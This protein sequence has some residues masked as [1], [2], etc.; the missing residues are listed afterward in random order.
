MKF[1][2]DKIL[3]ESDAYDYDLTSRILREYPAAQ[4]K[5]GEEALLELRDMELAGDP[6]RLGKRTLRLMIGKGA[7]VKDCP[8]TNN[9]VCCGLKIL[10]FGQGCPMDCTYCA[11]Q[12][13]FNRPA[14]ELFVN[15]GDI[16]RDLQ[17]H[18][19][20][21]PDRFHRFCTGEFADSLALDPVTGFASELVQV[22]NAYPNASLELKTKSDNVDDLLGLKPSGNIVISF[23]VN[24]YHI[25]VAQEMR[26]AGLKKRLL[27]AKKALDAGYN[28]GFH[29][30]PIIPINN[31]KD[32][33]RQTIDD[34]YSIIDPE[35]IPWISLG[36][37]RFVPP[38]KEIAI[39][40]FGPRDLFHLPYHR[41]LDGK[42]RIFS[43]KRIEIY[44]ELIDRI[45][46]YDPKARVYFCMESPYIWEKAM[47][48]KMDSDQG[49]SDYLD[50]AFIH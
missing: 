44:R 33:Y 45:R 4:V 18:L 14:I 30:D 47:G 10:H 35:K 46:F 11:L 34:I 38:L 29:F 26:A 42:F 8:G 1:P 3:I 31:W 6:F 28:I 48:M 39:T 22:F 21:Q 25:G 32:G 7:L 50:S 24:T 19:E 40:R 43:E 23:S 15:Q 2:I 49:L 36:I 27:A 41:G 12:V 37:L 16:V 13:Y 17:N 20:N 5:V 9:Y